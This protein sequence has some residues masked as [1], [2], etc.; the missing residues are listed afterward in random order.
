MSINQNEIALKRLKGKKRIEYLFRVGE[1]LH[2]KHLLLRYIT[3]EE[4]DA[5]RMGVSVAK[6]RFNKA[7]DRNRIKRQMREAV[8][9]NLESFA[10]SGMGMLIFKGRK[11]VET[12]TLLLECEELL[13]NLN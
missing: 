1:S 7:H 10:F 2:S 4:K 12:K 6:R 9:A 13:R 8:R 3:T 5:F 11:K